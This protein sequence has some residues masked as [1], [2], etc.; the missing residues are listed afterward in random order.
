MK[1]TLDDARFGLR[2]KRFL[3]YINN[4]IGAPDFARR[5][6]GHRLET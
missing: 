5:T 2:V 4:Q 3:P 1:R 6:G